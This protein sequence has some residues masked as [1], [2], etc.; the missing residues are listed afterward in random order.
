MTCQRS[1][2]HLAG[3]DLPLGHSGS[4]EQLLFSQDWH[5]N[6]VS[7]LIGP[8]SSSLSPSASPLLFIYKLQGPGA[9]RHGARML[10][11]SSL[12]F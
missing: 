9:E 3:T 10:V 5:T 2:T 12:S 7:R 4:D 8:D 1:R 11:L 6:V